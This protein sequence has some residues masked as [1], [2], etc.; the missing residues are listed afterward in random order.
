MTFEIKNET[1]KKIPRKY[2]ILIFAAVLIAV[3]FS[4][5]SVARKIGKNRFVLYYPLVG[6]DRLVKEVRYVPKNP[7][8]DKI[9]SYVEELIDGSFIQ[10]T[11]SLFS[12]G[13][14]LEF[15]F[16]RDDELFVGVSKEALYLSSDSVSIEDGI[17]YLKKNVRKNFHN[18]KKISVFIDG[19]YIGEKSE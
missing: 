6:K 2:L 12:L 11:R 19:N 17:K 18:V 16:V 13:T 1:T 14:V 4:S 5:V 15:C 3:L 7:S 8:Q 10:R 9:V